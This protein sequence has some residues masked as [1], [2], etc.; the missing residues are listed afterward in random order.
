M[1]TVRGS[2]VLST[3]HHRV[4]WTEACSE[5]FCGVGF[6]HWKTCD[7]MLLIAWKDSSPKWPATVYVMCGVRC[8]TPLTQLSF[9]LQTFLICDVTYV[10]SFQQFQLRVQCRPTQCY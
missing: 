4:L 7:V 8:K 3:N 1:I 10:T 6:F 2:L 9:T 5:E